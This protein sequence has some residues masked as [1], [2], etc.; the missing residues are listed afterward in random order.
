MFKHSYHFYSET[1]YI[2]CP[3]LKSE[4]VH[5]NHMFFYYKYKIV[6]YSQINK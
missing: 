6:E 2:K 3:L 5:F 1:K 4:N